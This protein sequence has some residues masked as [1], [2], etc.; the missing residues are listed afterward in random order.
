MEKYSKKV[1]FGLFIKK[2][3]IINII[4]MSNIIKDSDEELIQQ[5][6]KENENLDWLMAKA[7]VNCYKAGTL[8]KI[9]EERKKIDWDAEADKPKE[10]VL[11]CVN[12]E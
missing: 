1:L 7:L 11:K 10:L 12:V 9:M 3:I 4:N 8:D 2:K 6:M 5:V